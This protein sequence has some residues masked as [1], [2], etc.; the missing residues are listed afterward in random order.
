MQSKKTQEKGLKE[1]RPKYPKSPYLRFFSEKMDEIKYK[2]PNI[3]NAREIGKK[4]SIKWNKLSESDKNVYSEKFKKDF[5]KY[6][7][8]MEKYEKNNK[9]NNENI[10]IRTR[11]Q[12]P[13]N[14]VKVIF[15][16]FFNLKI[17]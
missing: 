10:K 1:K 16:L 15:Y 9:K 2:F 14:I 5:D 17:I 4:V 7:I 13:A 12:G 8:E 11:S 6:K 3:K